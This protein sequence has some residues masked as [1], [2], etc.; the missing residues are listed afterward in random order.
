MKRL[1][2]TLL[3]AI[4]ILAVLAV[5]AVVYVTTFLDPEDL[6][7]RLEEVVQERIGLTLSLEGPISW[8]FYP[9]LG[10]GVEQ[11]EA[12]LPEQSPGE[13][14]AFMAF[15]RA[16][17]SLAVTSLLRGEVA[18][19]G[20][21]LD[22]LRLNLSRDENG[23]GNW[24]ALMERFA[25]GDDSPTPA[26]ASSAPVPG[27]GGGPTVAFNIASV[28]V[29]DGEVSYTDRAAGHSLRLKGLSITGRNVNPRRSFPFTAGF[30]LLGHDTPAGVDDTVPRLASEVTMQGRLALALAERRYTLE[31]LTLATRNRLAGVE[32]PQQLE[33]S[34]KRLVVDMAER[35]LRLEP[36]TLKATL[37][38]PS[39]GD[40]PLSLAMDFA[41]ESDLAAG[42]ARLRDLT[43]SG[44]DG[45]RLSGNLNLA[46]LYE[47]PRYDGQ[48]RL[49]PLSLRPWLERFDSLPA[50]AD[51]E[52]LSDVAL[53]TP[54]QGDLERVDLTGM[55]LVLD[56]STFTGRLAAG[57]DGHRLDAELQGDSLDLDAYLP[58]SPGQ[59]P[60]AAGLGLPGVARA[61][62][63]D[64]VQALL[65]VEWLRE[66]A[67]DTSLS[68]SSLRLAGLDFRD[69]ALRLAGSDGR[70]RLVSLES[71]FYEGSLT[72]DGELDLTREPIAW[73]LAPRLERVRVAT[74]LEALGEGEEPAPLRG[75]A[76]V[77]G[78]LTTQGNAWPVLK[79]GLNGR[80]AMR[81][82]DGAI[83]DVNVS[84]ELCSAVATLQGEQTQREWEADTRFERAEATLSVR[85]GVVESD[86]I[87]V[88]LPGIDVGGEGTLDLT[89]ERFDLRAAARVVDTAD[90][91]CKVNPRLE[92]LPLPV[93]CEG[94]LGGDSAEWCRFDREGFTA[95]IGEAL[96]EELGSRAGDEVEQRLQGALDKLEERVGEDAGRELRD[97]LKGLF[98]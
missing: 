41:L 23:R 37:A 66:L 11:A 50:T 10:V 6:K 67:L 20:M 84:R 24:E 8:S 59:A 62:A 1:L 71:A 79:R 76:S 51:P 26:N 95:A 12:W 3:A 21:T 61:F 54:L 98:E 15:R 19:D 77:E 38:H 33:L 90:L 56:G 60:D 96:R 49:A 25:A 64:E 80:L 35:H 73:R 57:L 4:G 7:P 78:E 39:L 36:G 65:P 28:E 44:D 87:I 27:G 55:T 88:T 97:A 43:L 53:T 81:L 82:D 83:L 30:Q 52:A 68:L 5:G 34:G 70:Q 18:I 93:R 13:D 40:T 31:D 91:A 16:E 48:L 58:A 75:R 17:V 9:R 74:L 86:D 32:S 22:G 94:S 29:K 42:S 89:S 14:S 92:R 63:Q 69:V 45:L 72:A 46:G 2:S 47:T 85:D